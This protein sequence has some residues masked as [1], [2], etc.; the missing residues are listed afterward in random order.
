MASIQSRLLLLNFHT[1]ACR[2]RGTAYPR[3]FACVEGL[4]KIGI[5]SGI[6]GHFKAAVREVLLEGNWNREGHWRRPHSFSEV[7]SR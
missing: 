6:L 1:Q 4:G 3:S 5:M 2:T 7:Q